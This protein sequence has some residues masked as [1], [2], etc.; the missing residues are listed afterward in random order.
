MAQDSVCAVAS[1]YVLDARPGRPPNPATTMDLKSSSGASMV[2]ALSRYRLGVGGDRR[3]LG[4]ACCFGDLQSGVHSR[5]LS[6][7]HVDCTCPAAR[8]PVWRNRAPR[9]LVDLS[10][11]GVPGT[12]RRSSSTRRGR[13]SRAVTTRSDPTSRRSTRRSSSGPSP[14]SWFGPKPAVVAGV[15]AVFAGPAHPADPGVLPGDLLLLPRRVLQGVL[16]GS[17]GRAR[18]AS[19][20]RPTG[21]RIRSR[22][23]CR[24]SIATCCSCRSRVLLIL[25]Y[26]VWKAFWFTDPA[27]GNRHV[28]HRRRNAAA[29]RPTSCCSADICFGC[30]SMRHVVGGCVNQLSQAPMGLTCL[31]VREL[32]EPGAHGLGVVQPVLG[33]L[34]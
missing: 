1:L 9:H 6:H 27:T 4:S 7:G 18:S 5:I 12:C 3:T 29:R 24:T 34:Q 32:S 33:R 10:A 16:G 23:S 30:H 14:H 22:S 20:A 26:D 25:A 15:A 28:R 19:R 2:W 17:A 31:L 13:R 21:A 8:A 11:A